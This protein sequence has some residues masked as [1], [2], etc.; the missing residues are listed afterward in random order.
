MG[1]Q[2]RPDSNF[3]AFINYD[4][5][6]MVYEYMDL[7]PLS[8][9]SRGLAFSCTSAYD[10]IQA[11]AIKERCKYYQ[12][13]EAEFHSKTS[14]NINILRP[15]MQSTFCQLSRVSIEVPTALIHMI[16]P[17][18]PVYNAIPHVLLIFYPLFTMPFNSDTIV[19]K[20]GPHMRSLCHDIEKGYPALMGVI[21]MFGAIITGA[22]YHRTSILTHGPGDRQSVRS[23][24]ILSELISPLCWGTDRHWEEPP[25]ARRIAF[26]WDFRQQP[27]PKYGVLTGAS[28]DASKPDPY[29]NYTEEQAAASRTVLYTLASKDRLV[30][31]TGLMS[32]NGWALSSPGELGALR[33]SRVRGEYRDKC[34]SFCIGLEHYRL[35]PSR[36]D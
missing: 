13:I 34:F 14:H 3:D 26:G 22:V 31:G 5:R 6:H 19:I 16:T 1:N 2:S 20:D 4:V 21:D 36:T 7:P 12:A 28:H 10:E 15:T 35:L 9:E 23:S 33:W 32:S 25:K 8:D 17:Q 29:H 18:M 30:G 11:A 27:S 24:W